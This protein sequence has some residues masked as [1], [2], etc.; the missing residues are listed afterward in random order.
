MA[1]HG[2]VWVKREREAHK[3]HFSTEALACPQIKM[4]NAEPHA[5][6]VN[7]PVW[8]KFPLRVRNITTGH[9]LYFVFYLR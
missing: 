6:I 4:N 3:T 7:T 2:L 5:D 9:L 8:E 1:V